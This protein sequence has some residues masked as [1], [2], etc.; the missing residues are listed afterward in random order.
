MRRLLIADAL[1]TA[2]GR[3][4][5]QSWMAVAAISYGRGIAMLGLVL[6][7]GTGPYT[8]PIGEGPEHQ[9]ALAVQGLT[10][11]TAHIAQQ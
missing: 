1:L 5:W 8:D 10:G 9:L 3:G 11:R 2:L 7:D 6:A 4:R